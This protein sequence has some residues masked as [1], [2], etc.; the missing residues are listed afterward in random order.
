MTVVDLHPE[1]LL[2]KDSRGDL[3]A[4]EGVRLE[5]HLVRCAA[6]RAER[7]LRLD[8]AAELDGD[9]RPS[10]ILGLVQ[11]ALK[12]ADAGAKADAK[13]K[14]KAKAEA[15]ADAEADAELAKLGVPGLRRRPRRTAIVLLFAAAVLAASAA[16]ATGLTGR[17][18]LN[19]RS[20]SLDTTHP[21]L[22]PPPPTAPRAP[23][24]TPAPPPAPVAFDP[25]S[26]AP[27][28]ET[29][30]TPAPA[31]APAPAL[32]L[33]PA[34][35]PALAPAPASPSALFD[36]ANAARRAGDVTTA[37]ALYDSLDRAFPNSREARSAKATGGRLLLDSGNA[38]GALARFDVYLASG[39][40]ELR[41]EAMAGR[42]T[43]LER[44][45][46]D[47]DEFRAWA[48]LLATYPH[49]PYASHARARVGRSL[50][51]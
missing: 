18:W 26:P 30:L 19:L 27:T 32:A 7:L 15:K 49:T 22:D 43:A 41:E 28:P 48:G 38:A 35:A 50:P 5:A 47:E 25:P 45:G 51:R 14:A 6:C 33:A 42:A 4:D 9:D 13:A 12:N 17:V 39:A 11:G 8:F 44:L 24:L 1:D 20:A 36:S 34:P 29:S 46:R 40:G 21:E 10:A 16:G 37:L 2:D 3:T 23:S 31:P